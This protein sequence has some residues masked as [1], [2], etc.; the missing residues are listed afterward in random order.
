MASASVADLG[1]A[2]RSQLTFRGLPDACRL[3][4]LNK[5]RLHLDVYACLECSLRMTDHDASS[6]SDADIANF[7]SYSEQKGRA[8]RVLDPS[9]D[10]TMGAML[11]GTYSASLAAT[12]NEKRISAVVNCCDIEKLDLP[13]YR[14]WAAAVRELERPP[15]S[16][17][18]LRLGWADSPAQ[19]MWRDTK[20]DQLV[21]ALRFIHAARLRG[22]NVLVHCMA[23]I[24]RSGAVAIACKR[25]AHSS[26]LSPHTPSSPPSLI[27]VMASEGISFDAALARVQH[28][29]PV[30][31][32][33]PGFSAQLR[34]F[35]QM[36]LLRELRR[37]LALLPG[38]IDAGGQ[39]SSHDLDA[40][41]AELRV[42]KLT[43]LA[44]D[45]EGAA[46]AATALAST[47]AATL[48]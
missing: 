44:R 38:G 13:L 45:V 47:L 22:E 26:L 11:V 46:A 12:V 30:V 28:R 6:V 4:R 35:D 31:Q 34:E 1:A 3:F 32:P 9:P 39:G 48:L 10:G 20:F 21:E 2:S 41:A 40:R 42:A 27:D 14:G 29:R 25:D 33:N 17:R 19:R 23:G 24:S 18:I 15:R 36:P 8:S 37:E 43:D 7:V 16:L 5:A